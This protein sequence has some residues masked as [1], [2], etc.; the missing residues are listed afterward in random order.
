MGGGCFAQDPQRCL[1]PCQP[2]FTY[3][4]PRNPTVGAGLPAM[5][6]C[7]PTFT[8]LTPRNPTVGAGLPA[9]AA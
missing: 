6:G 8:Y 1:T 5:T 7:Q 2:T 9:I 3:L 4:T